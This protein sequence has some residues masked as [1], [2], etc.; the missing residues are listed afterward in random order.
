MHLKGK[1]KAAASFCVCVR[2]LVF[3]CHNERFGLKN[4]IK[5]MEASRTKWK[6]ALTSFC[7]TREWKSTRL[8]GDLMNSMEGVMRTSDVI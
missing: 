2:E 4:S 7:E 8:V 3:I 6:T 5:A 1:L